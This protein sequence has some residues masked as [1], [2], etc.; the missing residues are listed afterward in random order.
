[1]SSRGFFLYSALFFWTVVAVACG[2]RTP[3]DAFRVD[4][5]ETSGS[6]DGGSAGGVAGTGGTA[7]GVGLEGGGGSGGVGGIIMPIGG[8]APECVVFNSD[9]ALAPLDLFFMLDSSGSMDFTTQGGI[10]KWQ[11]VR[12]AFNQF[13]NDPESAK[14]GVGLSFFPIIDFNE[15]DI[16]NAV[17]MPCGTPGNCK[18]INVCPTSFDTCDTDQ[19]CADAGFPQDD[20]VPYGVC[21]NAPQFPCLPTEPTFNCNGNTGP[22]VQAGICWDHYTCESMPYAIPSFGVSQLPGAANGFI[23]TIDSKIPDG[24]TPTLP[25]IRGSVD[26]A[27]DFKNQNPAHT[28]VVVLTTDGLPTVCDPD[29]ELPDETQAIQNLADV[30][31]S[32]F[33]QDIP[34]W[35]I[36][37]FAPD[38]QAEAQANLDAIALAGGT[39]TAFIM[40]TAGPVT[41]QFLAAL[42][43]VRANALS[44]EF[45]LL[46]SNDPIDYEETWI[47]VIDDNMNQT[48]I[49]RVAGPGSCP[50]DGH[51]FH[52]DVD[53]PPNTPNRIILCPFSC[54]EIS[55]NPEQTIEVFS[56]CDDPPG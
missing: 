9:A 15:P 4:S 12:T 17:S 42:N 6:G 2:A 33:A 13:V 25:A 11:A 21:A 43:E 28:V 23:N 38:E 37:V 35:V 7:T 52:Y 50:L 22:C 18:D 36:G 27:I 10:T 20:C 56:T 45:E 34:V 55:S 26:G 49:P 44:C 1:M 5:E 14:I 24:A 48:W 51:G 31:A 19:D 47:R 41:D 29:L 53:V 16:C 30:A 39:G 54:D 46:P 3:L 32:A 40:N 8:N